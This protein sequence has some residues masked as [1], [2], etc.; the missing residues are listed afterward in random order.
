M[1]IPKRDASAQE[2]TITMMELRQQP[3]NA[4]DFVLAGGTI[5]ITKNGKNVATLA[6]HSD[7]FFEKLRDARP[8]L[9]GRHPAPS[10]TKGKK[11]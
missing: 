1:G 10:D 2:V 9:L 5:H 6:P 7:A 3:G 4:L 11:T 8:Q